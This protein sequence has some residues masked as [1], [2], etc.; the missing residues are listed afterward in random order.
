VVFEQEE[1][2]RNEEHDADDVLMTPLCVLLWPIS[3]AVRNVPRTL[4][5]ESQP[6]TDQWTCWCFQYPRRLTPLMKTE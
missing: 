6:T 5:Q 2:R 1:D 3:H 4:P